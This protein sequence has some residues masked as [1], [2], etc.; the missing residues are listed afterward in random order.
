MHDPDFDS[1]LPPRAPVGN[2]RKKSAGTERVE[3]NPWLTIWTRPRGTMREIVET[4]PSRSVMLL[5]AISGVNS[6]LSRL[7]NKNMGDQMTLPMIIA[8]ALIGGSIGGIISNLLCGALF[9]WTGSW[10]GGV[11]NYEETRAAIAWGGVPNA[12]IL[13]A[14]IGLT[15]V[16]GHELFTLNGMPGGRM[17]KAYVLIGNG[18]LQVVLGI[19]AIVLSIK[20]L[21]EV[22]RFSAWSALGSVILAIFALLGIL[23]V[24][25]ILFM[26]LGIL[27]MPLFSTIRPGA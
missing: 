4:D 19:W 26:V 27:F 20:C 15:I 9:R 3:G 5:A 22:H 2:L 21:A 13:A 12:V 14:M 17:S 24:I 18:S 11:A 1:Y 8:I 6:T 10:L 16:F 7:I 25:G 23:I